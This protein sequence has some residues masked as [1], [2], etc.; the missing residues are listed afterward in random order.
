MMKWQDLTIVTDPQGRQQVYEYSQHGELLQAI[1]P[2]GAQ[3]QYHYNLHI[4]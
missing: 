3:W 4:N 2:N 1:A